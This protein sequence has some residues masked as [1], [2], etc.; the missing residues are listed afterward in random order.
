MQGR[1]RNALQQVHSREEGPR[2]TTKHLVL[3]KSKTSFEFPKFLWKMHGK[4]LKRS[5]FSILP[6]SDECR[7]VPMNSDEIQEVE[8]PCFSQ[9]SRFPR[10][11]LVCRWIW[12]ILP[13]SKIPGKWN[14]GGKRIRWPFLL[15]PP[16]YSLKEI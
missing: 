15:S 1:S 3:L 10:C 5:F 8:P 2:R 7:R 13:S 14:M 11:D 6:E 12:A 9:T 4:T 16:L